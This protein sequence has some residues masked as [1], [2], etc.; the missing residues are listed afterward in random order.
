VRVLV[1]GAGWSGA[2]VAERLAAAGLDVHVYE[3]TMAAGGHARAERLNGVVFEP[4]GAH[5]FHT[6]NEVV[7]RYVMRFGMNRSYEHSVAARVHVYP[8][9]APRLLSWPPQVGELRELP[10]WRSIERE[11]AALPA[12][13]TGD[14]LESYAISLMGATLYRLFVKGYTRKQWGR[15]PKDLSSRFAPKR[16]DLRRDGNR[17]LFTDKWEFFP[18]G[19]VNS[20]VERILAAVSVAYGVEVDLAFLLEHERGHDAFVITSPLDALLGRD[21]ELEWRGIRLESTYHPQVDEAGTL[22][23][24][25]VVNWPDERYAFTRSIETKQATGQAILGTVVSH[26]YPGAAT[27]HYPVPT[28]DGRNERRNEELK[29]EIAA[30]LARP[31]F[32]C[33]RLAD[34]VYINQ[35]EAIA[36]AMKC[37]ED[38]VRTLT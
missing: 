12:R 6:S 16:I 32:F 29:Q 4:N 18:S 5:I 13:P 31:V 15:D 7:A 35:D 1:V 26:E 8:E 33:G 22:T 25:Y 27:R 36:R 9:E 30:A 37:S 38:V 20:V 28:L 3:R 2:V 19:G 14:D 10:I 17:R 34:Y 23:D 21:G 11:L 24:A